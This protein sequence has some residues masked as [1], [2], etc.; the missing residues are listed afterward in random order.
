MKSVLTYIISFLLGSLLTVSTVSANHV[1]GAEMT[2]ICLGSSKFEVTVKAYRDCGSGGL[3]NNP[4]TITNVTTGSAFTKTIKQISIRDITKVCSTQVSKCFGGT[5]PFGIEEF[6]FRD[7]ID[8]SAFTSW[9]KYRISWEQGARST[10][11]TTGMGGQNL[12][13]EAL[14]DKCVSPCN[15][16][17]KYTI[18]PNP[19][20][21]VDKDFCYNYGIID[22]LDGDSIAFSLEDPLKSAGSPCSYVSGYNKN[23]PLAFLGFPNYNASL[24]AGFHIDALSGEICFRPNTVQIG[25][26][27][28]KA[29]EWRRINGVMV[30]IGETRRDMQY[31]ITYCSNSNKNPGI[32]G[33]STNFACAGSQNCFDI[34]SND[35]NLTDSVR[36]SWNKGIPAAT[37]TPYFASGSRMQKATFCWTPGDSDVRTQSY[38]FTVVAKDNYCPQ[39]GVMSVG[40][41]LFVLPKQKG[42]D[43]MIASTT[44]GEVTFDA[45]PIDTGSAVYIWTIKDSTTVLHIDTSQNFLH[46][47]AM[48]GRYY[49]ELTV[50]RTGF[51][52]LK[53]RDTFDVDPFLSVALPADTTVCRGSVLQVNPSVSAG[54][55]PYR[56]QW[57]SSPAD[58]FSL[59][60]TTVN[61]SVSYFLTVTD[62]GNCVARDTIILTARVPF[63]NAGTDKTIC[64]P[65]GI[66]VL[67]GIPSGGSWSGTGITGNNFDPAAAGT[68]VHKL[69]YVFVD[70]TGCSGSDTVSMGVFSRPAVSAGSDTSVC[71]NVVL[72]LKGSPV[73]G[74]WSGMGILGTL[75]RPSTLNPGIYQLTYA[76]T[77]AAGC[78]ANDTMSVN[79]LPLPSVNAGAD[80]TLCEDGLSF[81]LSG[82]PAGGTWSGPGTSGNTFVPAGLAAKQT[83]TYIYTDNNG[84]S[85][86]D[87]R[88]VTVNPVPVVN[89]GI[90]RN[91]CLD[92]GGF[93]LGGVPASGIW[94]G[95]SVAGGVFYPAI[96]G[97]GVHRAVLTA[98]NPGGCS[99]KDSIIIS[100]VK[101]VAD[102]SAAPLIGNGPLTVG[103]TDLSAS[104]F[105]KLE[106]NFGDPS[107]PS[108]ISN[109]SAPVHVYTQKGL[110]TV[111]LITLDTS[112]SGCN[113]TLSKVNYVEVTDWGIGLSEADD[114]HGI[115][116]FPNPAAKSFDVFV[117]AG[118]GIYTLSMHDING[119]KVREINGVKTG[120]LHI[121]CG[122]LDAGM[123]F[124]QLTGSRGEY[125]KSKVVLE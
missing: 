45:V 12:F 23:K 111:T 102:F 35:F 44:C 15:S 58:T 98:T 123:Y 83:I 30:N 116:A 27:V 25:V 28:V 105:K 65:A 2:Y 106:W 97:K 31:N 37:F 119:K 112:I 118:G 100:V 16:S 32:S 21:C 79:V 124:L 20:L 4:I 72:V 29:T 19:I 17:P 82:N 49:A 86:T 80:T 1:W 9:C 61:S 24:P 3:W 101:P 76:Y 70:S 54:G 91:L 95:T 51:C 7:T 99:A 60:N 63:T 93:L 57:S 52:N 38:N 94:S 40:I 41:K 92:G 75:F 10:S 78:S 26:V 14:L 64:L 71:N 88:D 34:L 22:T 36:L 50:V 56:Y 48:A 66:S 46:R 96:A 53:Y 108:N 67:S 11:I 68:G 114:L 8:L 62:S 81:L 107:S 121:D 109:Q 87:E 5:S 59:L 55:L 42:T 69:V 113:D 33:L 73:G 84:C 85:N 115:K 90:D 104:P 39:P 43:R 77:N 47:F 110:Y 122:G 13:I 120:T 18:P 117:N 103:F 6:V 125:F 89:A 74:S